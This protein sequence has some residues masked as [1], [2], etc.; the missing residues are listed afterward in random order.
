MEQ[1]AISVTQLSGYIKNIFEAEELLHNIS[2]YGEIS[3]LSVLRGN[4]YFSLKDEDAILSC[5]FFGT[6]GTNLRNGDLVTVT[7]TPRYYVK[8]GKLNFNV[9]KVE[10]FGIGELFKQFLETKERLAKEGLFDESKK[11]IIP[12]NIKRLGVVTSEMGAVI[13]DIIN[14]T[15]R[16]NKAVDVVLYPARVQGEG[17]DKDIIAGIKFFENYDV[18]VIIVARGG[19][20][21]EDLMPFNSEAL[22]RVAFACKK[23][24]I[25]AV[26]HETDFTII[27][28]VSDL[29]APTPSAAA[30]LVVSEKRGKIAEIISKH[31][32]IASIL[33]TKA[34]SADNILKNVRK[35]LE[36]ALKNILNDKEYSI[37]L[38]SGIL[39][40]LNPTRL[41]ERGF[42][43]IEKEG[44]SVTKISDLSLKDN[45]EIYLKD[46]K[47][48]SEVKTIKSFKGE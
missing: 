30:E 6:E 25:S 35:D 48:T 36:I 38:A 31:D 7:G 12:Q 23:P 41:M 26:G 39:E 42:A 40:K 46:G 28:F 27:D 13:Q 47:I 8:G 34:T 37:N 22:A 10:P 18:D 11:K 43:K 19:G 33:V 29:R 20:S 3:G 17:A 14:V 9:I 4:A 2:V 32:R 5:V 15:T 1:K 24:L 45:L 16:R 44:R 21:F